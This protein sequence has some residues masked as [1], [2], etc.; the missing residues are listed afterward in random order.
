MKKTIPFGKAICY[1]GYRAGQNPEGQVPSKEEIREDLHIL[2]KDGY[3]Y[4]RMYDPNMHAERALQVIQEDKL[5]L[6]CVIGIDSF[7]ETNNPKCPFVEQ[8]YKCR[9]IMDFVDW[10]KVF[11]GKDPYTEKLQVRHN[12]LCDDEQPVLLTPGGKIVAGISNQKTAAE[13]VVSLEDHIRWGDKLKAMPDE[14][15][16][17]H[18]AR[19]RS[20]RDIA[21]TVNL[22][23][24]FVGACGG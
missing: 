6:R 9:T 8:H 1:S 22:I 24:D 20:Q 5:P 15:F 10:I 19:E 7:P 14:A 23:L 11:L 13:N 16:T 18:E 17:I 4:I 12:P 3:S 21:Y 2:V